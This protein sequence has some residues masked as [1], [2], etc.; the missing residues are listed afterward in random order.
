MIM[1]KTVKY[2][3]RVYAVTETTKP[4]REWARVSAEPNSKYDYTPPIDVIEESELIIYEQHTASLN[5][6][7]LVSV[8]NSIDTPE[9]PM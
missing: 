3:V 8:V 6:P 4:K 5:L 7:A 9:K 1:N 2:I